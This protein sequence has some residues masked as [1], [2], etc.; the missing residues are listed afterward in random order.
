MSPTVNVSIINYRT[1]EL[2]ISCVSSVLSAAEHHN[3]QIVIVDN[4][5]NDG[6][7]E[8]ISEW[9]NN[10][11]L[12]D[13]VALIQS[14]TNSGFSG[15]HNQGLSHNAAD[16]HLILNSDAL[17]RPD[18]FEAILNAAASNPQ[19]GFIAPRLEDEDGT[20]QVS[21]FRFHSPIGEFV[22]A[23]HTGF[24]TRAL[25]RW[26]IP[27]GIDPQQS[28]IEWASFACIL[29]RNEVTESVGLMDDNYFLYYEDEDFCSKARQKGWQICFA[30]QARAVHFR[31]GSGPV[32]A[33]EKQYKRRP[34]YYYQSR[35]RF[36]R[37]KYGALGFYLANCF[38]W[39]GRAVANFRRLVGK[40][41]PKVIEREGY[42][43]WTRSSSNH[44]KSS[45]GA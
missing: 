26:D 29:V 45:V 40:D 6:S 35:T 30:P 44:K 4:A 3:V 10:T 34:N 42:D 8:Q 17:L 39:L 5:S 38:W 28:A 9:I 36:F 27:L 31:G 22:R 11:K 41:V 37:K 18:F 12:E 15:G 13:R 23:A 24:I 19:A 21:C 1:G 20:P 7:A 32:K 33:L 25:K 43:I 14:E 16:F 2:T